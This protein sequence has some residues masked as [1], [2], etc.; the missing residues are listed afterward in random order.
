MKQNQYSLYH[1]TSKASGLCNRWCLIHKYQ[2][3]SHILYLSANHRQVFK[4][5]HLRTHAHAFWWL[6][7]R[8]CMEDKSKSDCRVNG[9]PPASRVRLQLRGHRQLEREDHTAPPL[10]WCCGVILSIS[11]HTQY[12]TRNTRLQSLSLNT[13]THMH[14]Y[15][16]S[17]SHPRSLSDKTLP[18][19]WGADSYS[20]GEVKM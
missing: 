16:S 18:Q 17:S 9:P 5:A 4:D 3:G 15:N 19:A 20:E 12:S 1:R 2:H 10:S 8:S 14:K 13:N 11:V 7:F 6:V